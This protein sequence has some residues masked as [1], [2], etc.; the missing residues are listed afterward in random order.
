RPASFTSCGVAQNLW[1]GLK[2]M[3]PSLPALA[4]PA[5]L[6][7]SLLPSCRSALLFR[8]AFPKRAGPKAREVIVTVLDEIELRGRKKGR[9]E[10]RAEGRAQALLELLKARFGRVPAKVSA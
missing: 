10:G 4:P 9:A 1:S 6:R 2:N 3:P 8:S 5:P 7:F